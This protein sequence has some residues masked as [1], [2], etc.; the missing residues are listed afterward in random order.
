MPCHTERVLPAPV[1]LASCYVGP[2]VLKQ[3]GREKYPHHSNITASLADYTHPEQIIKVQ[4]A[5][6]AA[7][8]KSPVSLVKSYES[9]IED[10]IAR[11]VAIFFQQLVVCYGTNLHFEIGTTLHQGESSK[12]LYLKDHAG[13]SEKLSVRNAAHSSTIPCLI[14]YDLQE[15][16]QYRQTGQN[17]PQGFVY[18]KGSDIYHSANAT[19]DMIR[20]INEAD[21]EIDGKKD[22]SKLRERALEMLNQASCRVIDPGTGIAQF[23]ALIIDLTSE[24]A[25]TA[26]K[27]GV[28]ACLKIYLENLLAIQDQIKDP[29]QLD[30]LLGVKIDESPS[31]E[32]IRKTIHQLR[33]K[34]IRDNQHVQSALHQKISAVSKQVLVEIDRKKK[35]D[36]YDV[37]FQ[38]VLIDSMENQNDKI[39]LKKL[40]NHPHDAYFKAAPGEKS[41]GILRNTEERRHRLISTIALINQHPAK[42]L[43]LA[44]ELHLEF[45]NLKKQEVLNRSAITRVI[46]KAKGWSQQDLADEIKKAFPSLPSSQS[47]ISNLET[48]KKIMDPAYAVKLS[49]VFKVDPSLFI[50]AFFC[51]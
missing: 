13:Q 23:L 5:A 39:N 21:I 25:K 19:L 38:N 26:K 30:N 2:P 40:F 15:W 42:I 35:P 49:N 43:A 20:D 32:K 22:D 31:S 10:H 41:P 27:P 50:P 51:A 9:M 8:L 33:F 46:R 3:M 16:T 6:E 45:R 47:T 12:A 34:A 1:N 18:I 48:S 37:A 4:N 7:A 36:Y 44:K 29:K 24:K 14:A 11:R 17:K 28:R